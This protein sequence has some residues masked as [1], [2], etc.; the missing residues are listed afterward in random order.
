[1]FFKII[2]VEKV[3]II[4]PFVS[5]VVKR[6]II[7]CAHGEHFDIPVGDVFLETGVLHENVVVVHGVGAVVELGKR[8]HLALVV[9]HETTDSQFFETEI[10]VVEVG[11]VLLDG[12]Q[13]ECIGFHQE[14]DVV[15]FLGVEGEYALFALGGLD[16]LL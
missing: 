16:H 12:L 14:D 15:L 11:E 8:H 10:R 13:G 5:F 9:N 3:G 7:G 2:F 6:G 1:M 4:S